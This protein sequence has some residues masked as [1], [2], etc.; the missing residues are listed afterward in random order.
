MHRS[1]IGALLLA[2]PTLA[3]AGDTVHRW[4]DEH[5]TVNYGDRPPEGRRT[6]PV[7]TSDP[8]GVSNS[9][10]AKPPPAARTEPAATVA[11]DREAVRQEVESA[12]RRE[13]AANALEAERRQEAA[14]IE[15]RRRCEE[16]R[17]V[18]CD[19][20]AVID[21][22]LYFAPPRILRRHQPG[23]PVVPVPP[24]TPAAPPLLMKRGPVDTH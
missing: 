23:M 12:L 16:Q 5:G 14:R 21:D 4:V 18:D 7:P 3:M 19:Q 15:A 24:P 9:P 13:Q 6:T 8:L 11:P 22:T 20:G 10:A 1:V 2:L 17:R